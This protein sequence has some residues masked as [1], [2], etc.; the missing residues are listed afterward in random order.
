MDKCESIDEKLLA[1]I[2]YTGFELEYYVQ[3]NGYIL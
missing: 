3:E 2:Q 1:S